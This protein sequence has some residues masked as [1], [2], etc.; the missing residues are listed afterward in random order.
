MY[1]LHV[2]Q[3]LRIQ[4]D[5]DNVATRY[6]DIALWIRSHSLAYNN[7]DHDRIVPSL[8]DPLALLT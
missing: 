4:N 8:N 2:Q 5:Q 3:Q 1:R 7:G 6:C